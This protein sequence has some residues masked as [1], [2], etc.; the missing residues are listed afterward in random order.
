[1]GFIHSAPTLE[2][3]NSPQATVVLAMSLGL[4]LGTFADKADDTKRA[5]NNLKKQKYMAKK[6]AKQL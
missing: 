3:N 5:K 4:Y 6:E 2:S 1:M